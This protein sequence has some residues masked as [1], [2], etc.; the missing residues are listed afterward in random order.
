MTDIDESTKEYLSQ[1]FVDL[2]CSGRTLNGVTF[3]DCTFRTCDFSET[4]LIKCRFIDCHFF[5]CNLSVVKIN[6]TRF[7]DVFFEACKL[8]GVDWTKGH[9]SS[10]AVSSPVRFS[11]CILNDSSFFGLDMKEMLMEACKAH[12]V[13]FRDAIL[14]GASFMHTDLSH[15]LFNKTNLAGANFAEASHYHID[16]Y[17]NSI[18]GAK[19]CRDEA[20]SLLDCLGIELID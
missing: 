16:L 17:A 1:K 18:K 10:L 14:A 11:E 3:D 5:Q 8:I 20:V 13:D 6:N 19:F 2:D 9:W 12:D 7:S 15:S 4:T